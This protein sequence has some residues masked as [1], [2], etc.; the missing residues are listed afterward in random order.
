MQRVMKAVMSANP[1]TSEEL[2]Q[3]EFSQVDAEI[4]KMAS[5]CGI[6]MLDRAQL[7]RVLENDASVCTHS[8]ELAF[9]KLHTLLKAHYLL[10]DRAADRIGEAATQKAID[11]VVSGLIRKFKAA[12]TGQAP[13]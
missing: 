5:L 4:S 12:H 9:E 8:N 11:E 7:R 1:V 10:R 13:Q 3:Y 2:W 6:D